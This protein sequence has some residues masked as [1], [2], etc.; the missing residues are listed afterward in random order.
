M[1]VMVTRSP[2]WPQRRA[3]SGEPA[4]RRAVGAASTRRGL[5]EGPAPESRRIVG[6]HR[7]SVARLAS[8]KGRLRRAGGD[9]AGHTVPGGSEPQR[10]A[11]SGEPAEGFQ[12]N[13]KTDGGMPQRRAGSGEPADRR[14]PIGHDRLQASTKGRLR[15]AG[16]PVAVRLR[17]LGIG[18]STKGR[19]RRAGGEVASGDID[20]TIGPQ[21]RAGSGEPAD[22]PY[23]IGWSGVAKPQRRAGSGEPAEP[24]STACRAGPIAS[25]KGRLRRAGGRGRGGPVPMEVRAS[26]KGRLRRA[27]GGR[28]QRDRQGAD[29]ASTKGRL[30]RAGGLLEPR[31]RGRQRRASTKGRLRRAGGDI[32]SQAGIARNTPQRRAGSG[33]PADG[34]PLGQVGDPEEAST[35]G[36]LRRA[37][38][39]VV[40]KG[41]PDWA[42]PQRRAGSGEPADRHGGRS[43]AG[44]VDASTKGRLRRAG[45]PALDA[46]MMKAGGASTKGRLRRA[47]GHDHVERGGG[48]AG[49]STK[50]RLRRA[51]GS[52]PGAAIFAMYSPQRR[53][54]SGEPADAHRHTDTTGWPRLNE[55]PA[56]ESRRRHPILGPEFGFCWRVFAR[57]KEERG[58]LAS[59]EPNSSA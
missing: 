3:G 49:A 13:V 57:G 32:A 2:S 48:P 23:G 5:N 28:G 16:G 17:F 51:G 22:P 15:R 29:E 30:R 50:G 24:L 42:R 47:G 55:G 11:G 25:T 39:P 27:G 52:P 21:R 20:G 14:V 31:Q 26:T 56:P 37:G 34:G 33:E 41:T 1:P 19:L 35:K 59:K 10:R 9:V 7:R 43:G 54:G 12:V 6:Q 40:P 36:R 44:R 38:G 58:T 18:A 4:D 8:T 53:A 45:G 46:L